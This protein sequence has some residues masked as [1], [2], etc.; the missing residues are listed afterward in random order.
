MK[1]FEQLS[2]ADQKA[3]ID[4]SICVTVLGTR[5]PSCGQ[6]FVDY[7][8]SEFVK[9][10]TLP[11]NIAKYALR[12]IAESLFVNE[13]VFTAEKKG[14]K[15]VTAFKQIGGNND[16]DSPLQEPALIS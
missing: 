6:Q 13:W 8:V 16:G 10:Y 14:P 3:A 11:P 7:V 2:E 1:P 12:E 15:L 9:S 5:L 4:V